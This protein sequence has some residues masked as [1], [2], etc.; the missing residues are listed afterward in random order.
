MNKTYFN[1]TMLRLLA[2]GPLDE[3]TSSS[4]LPSALL[5]GSGYILVMVDIGTDI[6]DLNQSIREVY[7][8]ARIIVVTAPESIHEGTSHQAFLNSL[9]FAI[10][11]ALAASDC[12]EPT[13]LSLQAR[14]RLVTDFLIVS[15]AER[16]GPESL[17][18]LRRDQGMPPAVLVA[19]DDNILK[20]LVKNPALMRYTNFYNLTEAGCMQNSF[21]TGQVDFDNWQYN[22]LKIGGGS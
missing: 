19:Y 17:Q 20:T 18:S 22:Q 11:P 1:R 2:K 16:L 4:Y 8:R 13:Y 15:H 9:E 14:Y 12:A 3:N 5:K 7:P 10:R 6:N 21:E